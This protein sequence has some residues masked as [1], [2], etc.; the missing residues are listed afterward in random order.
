[1]VGVE[2]VGCRGLYIGFQVA[3]RTLGLRGGVLIERVR[4][5]FPSRVVGLE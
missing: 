1:V 3:A 5:A 4:V 2:V